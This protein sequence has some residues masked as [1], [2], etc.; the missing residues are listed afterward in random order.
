M[1]IGK[2]QVTLKRNLQHESEQV[3]CWRTHK[4]SL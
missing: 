3:L 4:C 1:E 2:T